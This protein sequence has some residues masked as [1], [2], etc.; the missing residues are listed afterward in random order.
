MHAFD[1]ASD[2]LILRAIF[3]AGGSGRATDLAAQNLRNRPGCSIRNLQFLYHNL[4]LLGIQDKTSQKRMKDRYIPHPSVS[5]DLVFSLAVCRPF[6]TVFAQKLLG[7]ASA[8]RFH[9]ALWPRL[10]ANLSSNDLSRMMGD[11]TEDPPVG[12]RLPIT[13]YRKIVSTFLRK[14]GDP[15]QFEVAKTYFFDV[16]AHHSAKTANAVYQQD[17]DRL[18]GISPEHV[19]GCMKCCIQWHALIGIDQDHPLSVSAVGLEPLLDEHA[20]A[21][22]IEDPEDTRVD[23]HSIANGILAILQPRLEKI[24]DNR[25]TRTTQ[26][27]QA[28]YWPRPK[29]T[30]SPH[31]VRPISDVRPHGSRLPALRQVLPDFKVRCH[32]TMVLVEKMIARETNVLVNM[33]CGTGK[34]LIGLVA[35]KAFANGRKTIFILPHSGLHQDFRRRARD[36]T[37]THS[38]WDPKGEFNSD[39][40]IIYAA[41]EHI[42]FESFQI[43]LHDLCNMDR[44]AWIIFDEI[45][46][47]F[48]DS[49]YRPI[50]EMIPSLAQY[51]V[52]IL[53]FSGT[54]P[55]CLM[56]DFFR[57]TGIDRWDLIKTRTSRANALLY[58]TDLP[59]G[60]LSI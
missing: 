50:F 59:A 34:T 44:V 26:Y 35:A 3:G 49:R 30:Y 24:I 12:V 28:L 39:V 27:A 4:T 8:R 56:N 45:H 60:L 32:E 29:P 10:S 11:L 15:R 19:V 20:R 43:Y 52:L 40:E 31:D 53:G 36:L 41:V 22:T 21:L 9:E 51:G 18:P 57:L 14:H 33:G 5:R 17:R 1:L 42:D 6:Q 55:P 13:K 48:T 38:K 2:K 46:K 25:I 47:L 58:V 54:I 16:V 37:I 23:T 7:E